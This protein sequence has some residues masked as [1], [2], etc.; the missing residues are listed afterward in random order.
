MSSFE[1]GMIISAPGSPIDYTQGTTGAVAPEP[2]KTL[3]PDQANYA[4]LHALQQSLASPTA[5]APTRY[6][7]AS[8]SPSPGNLRHAGPAALQVGLA[9]VIPRWARSQTVN[10][11]ALSDGYPQPELAH[12]A[13]NALREAAEEWSDL[14]LGVRFKWVQRIQDA[15]F[16]LCYGG[17]HGE[18]FAQAFF[19]NGN[20]L[21]SLVVY[22]AAF[23]P[24]VVRY[25]KNI[26]LHELGHVLGFRHEFAPQVYGDNEGIQLG[27]RD[28]HSVM[29]DEFPPQLQASDRESAMAFYRFSGSAIGWQGSNEPPSSNSNGLPIKDYIA[30]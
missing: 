4:R 29:G 21:S 8:E 5:A 26:F 9:P 27:P 3:H 14:D 16:V 19:P 23:R 18:A 22:A 11:A 10:F 15:S 20:E 13:A 6:T 1:K 28:P 25:L 7:C 17:D 24:G 12:I 30:R 2:L